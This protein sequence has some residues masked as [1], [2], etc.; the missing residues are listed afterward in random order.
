[1]GNPFTPIEG[2]DRLLDARYLPLV[3]LEVLI[4][5]LGREKGAAPAGAF[6]QSLEP[7]LGIRV[8]PHRKCRRAHDFEACVSVVYNIPQKPPTAPGLR[9]G[10]RASASAGARMSYRPVPAVV[11]RGRPPRLPFSRA[12]AAFAT[13]RARPPADP[14]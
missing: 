10:S 5:R 11:L 8:D 13:L 6:G 9:A 1:M 14:S 12:A 3:D 4:D 7:L 2:C